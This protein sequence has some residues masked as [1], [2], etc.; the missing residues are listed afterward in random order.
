MQCINTALMFK[1]QISLTVHACSIDLWIRS[2]DS[3]QQNGRQIAD[4]TESHGKNYARNNNLRRE[5]INRM[6]RHETGLDDIGSQNKENKVEWDIRLDE[7]TALM[8]TKTTVLRPRDTTRWPV[9]RWRNHLVSAYVKLSGI[10]LL[11]RQSLRSGQCCS[12]WWLNTYVLN[13]CQQLRIRCFY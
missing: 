7:K 11:W 1:K 3:W 4:S 12:C 2:L 6:R 9:A 5:K 10:E 13:I 8:T